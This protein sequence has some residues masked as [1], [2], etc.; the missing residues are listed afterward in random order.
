MQ[1]NW[2]VCPVCGTSLSGEVPAKKVP[3]KVLRIR[4]SLRERF[5]GWCGKAWGRF[6]DWVVESWEA[7]KPVLSSTARIVGIL[8][9]MVAFFIAVIVVLGLLV[10]VVSQQDLFLAFVALFSTLVVLEFVGSLLE[11]WWLALIAGATLLLAQYTMAFI[12]DWVSQ[13][14][15]S[16]TFVLG[17]YLT[18]RF[19][20]GSQLQAA[21]D[22]G[23]ANGYSKGEQEGWDQAARDMAAL[24]QKEA[25][26]TAAETEDD[27]PPTT[28]EGED[29]FVLSPFE[30][31]AGLGDEFSPFPPYKG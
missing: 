16:A 22:E 21:Y 14:A 1:A 30:E 7:I 17:A 5:G 2:A 31:E 3:A 23:Y 6:V 29:E 19:F 4:P 10:P 26:E 11:E 18:R 15:F 24:K 13:A 20:G 25:A 8:V 9:A 27:A 12:D 28:T